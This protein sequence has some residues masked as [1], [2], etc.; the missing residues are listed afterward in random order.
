MTIA[1]EF[2]I[3]RNGFAGAL[4]CAGLNAMRAVRTFSAWRN[5]LQGT[6]P[7]VGMRG[8]AAM[9]TFDVALNSF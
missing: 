8:M 3:A 5:T 1:T 2:E 4:P 6:L 7:A 9:R